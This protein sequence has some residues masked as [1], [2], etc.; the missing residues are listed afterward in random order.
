MK[1]SSIHSAL[2]LSL[3]LPLSA[4][5]ATAGSDAAIPDNTSYSLNPVVVTGTGMHHRKAA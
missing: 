5:A 1:I 4:A 2:L 3:A